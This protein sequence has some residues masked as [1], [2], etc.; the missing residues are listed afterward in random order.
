MRTDA[1]ARDN[2]RRAAVARP[3]LHF[4]R[5]TVWSV[6]AALIA[7]AMFG[8]LSVPDLGTSLALGA[9]S[10][11]PP[12]VDSAGQIITS[13]I[14]APN[15]PGLLVSSVISRLFLA[16]GV[17]SPVERLGN[18]A[19]VAGAL[20]VF[21]VV[22][23]Y[24]RLGLDGFPAVVGA[25]V[26]AGGASTLSLVASGSPDTLV[27]PLLLGLLLSGVWWTQTC[28][29]PALGML[30]VLTVTTVGSYPV[31][32]PA[33][34]VIVGLQ[35]DVLRRAKTGWGPLALTLA[36]V[37]VGLAHRA[38][39]VGLLSAGE[40]ARLG[41]GAGSLAARCPGWLTSLGLAVREPGG[42]LDVV[43]G[44]VP[45][46]TDELGLLGSLLVGVGALALV[47]GREPGWLVCAAS[48]LTAGWIAV[49]TSPTPFADQAALMLL[50]WLPVGVGLQ[51]A[52]TT[53]PTGS[54]WFGVAVLGVFL[55]ASNLV[56]HDGRVPW[57]ADPARTEHVERL[58][59]TM[60]GA[61]VVGE[62]PALESALPPRSVTS[63][64]GILTHN[65]G[66]V[67][68]AYRRGE[69]PFAFQRGRQHLERF[70]FQFEPVSLPAARVPFRQFLEL[71]P[72]RSVVAAVAGPRFTRMI[73]LGAESVFSVIGG[74][75]P[76]FGERGVYAVVGVVHG[77][78]FAV[79]RTARD[80]VVLD[81][82]AG[83]PLGTHPMRASA[84]LR[85]GSD[86]EGAW[87]EVGGERLAG[88]RTGLAL[89]ALTPDGQ[90]LA[91]FGVD[92]VE[93]DGQLQ[94]PLP[95]VG[96]RV[97]RLIGAEPCVPLPANQWV[98]VAGATAA[99]SVASVLP[100][101][102]SG[103]IE[104]YLG[105]PVPLRPVGAARDGWSSPAAVETRFL[106]ANAADRSRL[107]VA[108]ERDGAPLAPRLLET[109]VVERLQL[110]GDVV[111]VS[112]LGAP[113]AAFARFTPGRSGVAVV[114]LCGSVWGDARLAPEDGP[115]SLISVDQLDGL[116]W[117][118]HG[119]EQDAAG[120]FR[121]SDG[122]ETET[123]V[124]LTRTGRIRVEVDAS[125]A[126]LDL[127][128]RP[129]TLTLVVNGTE[130]SPVAMTRDPQAY[131]WP[132]PRTVWKT[133]MNRLG[134]RVSEAV[135]PATL[136]IS[137]DRRSLGFALR[138]LQLTRLE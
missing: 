96:P 84:A 73:G 3:R 107:D 5:E 98:D 113:Q 47:R 94:V 76:S 131:A 18:M 133:G 1:R 62:Y 137:A 127:T 99:A 82:E 87:V 27:V 78:G 24:R 17:G 15:A 103:S 53:S 57:F 97:W 11:L 80:R 2:A 60:T 32:L 88:T 9:Q 54:A 40:T 55:M 92:D 138:R 110:A 86:E 126:A 75:G 29:L 63:G 58:L 38:G 50:V 132:V 124:Q 33:V 115:A 7:L 64:G 129:V 130:M 19:V 4:M 91:S 52:L 36:G 79:E 118:W 51:W 109:A 77:G 95:R 41:L 112:L 128:N 42:A 122:P 72:R 23:I 102:G 101:D 48:V 25:W 74:G 104:L 6:G 69:R 61:W 30:A 34:V 105:A 31:T 26:V 117:G 39:A 108:L 89:V 134:L 8:L 71:L 114:E 116:G 106:P 135:S 68:G 43:G 90:V 56:R 81:I 37:G 83:D 14:G 44:V 85:L 121:W 45:R 70:G 10:T 16:V 49:S 67:R 65:V 12:S 66:M 119:V 123:L 46:L 35:A 136:G 13:R 111:G 59:A 100:P 28:G 22:R 93:P 125:G 20:S 21:L 120:V